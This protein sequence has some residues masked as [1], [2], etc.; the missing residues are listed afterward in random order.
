MRALLPYFENELTFL[1]RRGQSVADAYDQNRTI[2][3]VTGGL[4]IASGVFTVGALIFLPRT[5][6]TAS[7]VMLTPTLSQPGLILSGTF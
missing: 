1:R 3:W 6:S 4:A 7:R 5:A 2:A